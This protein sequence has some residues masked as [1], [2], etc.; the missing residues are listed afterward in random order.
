MNR[1]HFLKGILYVSSSLATNGLSGTITKV[2]GSYAKEVKI[3]I[4]APSHCCVP[5][6]YAEQKGYF[7]KEG[8]RVSLQN[9]K[10]MPELVKDI[11]SGKIFAGQVIGPM[12]FAVHL[13]IEPFQSPVKMVVPMILGIHGSNIMAVKGAGIQ[14]FKDFK[15]KRLASHSK[16]SI[17]Y[18]LTK[19]FLMENGID[20]EKDAS[21]NI[22]SLSEIEEYVHKKKIDAFMMP[23]PVNAVIESKGEAS[24]KMLNKYIWKNHPCCVLTMRYQDFQA[25]REVVKAITRATSKASIELFKMN[26][27]TELVKM[28]R[29]TQYGFL[30][31]PENTL[32][33]AF[34][35]ERSDWH[36]FPYQST[37]EVI[38]KL[39]QIFKIAKADLDT[40]KIAQEVFLSELNKE[41]LNEIG[42]RPP[43]Q[44]TRPEFLMGERFV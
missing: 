35:K 2:F 29:K 36:P 44:N 1:R 19:Y 31:I 10:T 27:R 9:Y 20:P 4:F 6:V 24:A 37:G 30:E 18:L 13:G 43:Y 28:L 40:K 34:S 22:V 26:D 3:G 25:E 5:L 14:N 11:L 23:E 7:K 39:M 38:L 8:L 33:L 32:T 41:C 17:H 12:V 16:L 21:I 42:I 15:G